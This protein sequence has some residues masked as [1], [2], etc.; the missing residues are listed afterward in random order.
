MGCFSLNPLA[1]MA[2]SRFALIRVIRSLLSSFPL[3]ASELSV[4]RSSCSLSCQQAIIE[5]STIPLEDHVV[6]VRNCSF[7]VSLTCVHYNKHNRPFSAVIMK[8]LPS[9]PERMNCNLGTLDI[10]NTESDWKRIE[11]ISPPIATG[12]TLS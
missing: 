7:G 11:A 9:G 5:I 8:T 3:C 4:V 12:G 6:K 2:S 1:Y 10:E